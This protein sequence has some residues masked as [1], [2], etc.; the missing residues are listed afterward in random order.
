MT[1]TRFLAL[2]A[3]R[4]PAQPSTNGPSDSHEV[5]DGP[6]ENTALPPH[7]RADP[8]HVE[9]PAEDVAFDV[10][11]PDEEIDDEDD[12]DDEGDEEP[13]AEL[14]LTYDIS[15]LFDVQY[16]EIDEDGNTDVGRHSGEDTPGPAGVE[17]ET[18]QDYL[19]IDPDTSLVGS[20]SLHML[21]EH[22]V[23]GLLHLDPEAL[24]AH[25]A[26]LH[27]CQPHPGALAHPVGDIRFRPGAAL[28]VALLHL[29]PDEPV[30][31]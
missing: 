22:S 1:S 31:A 26:Y 12:E 11:E 30:T 13:A 29:D 14:G 7:Q 28:A 24:E 18:D 4:S 19:D 15:D 3:R 25:H 20:L 10:T 5:P 17:I 23:S 9:N 27:A 16:D 8:D 21:S 2:G 6:P